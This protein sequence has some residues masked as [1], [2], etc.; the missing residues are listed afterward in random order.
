[1]EAGAASIRVE[2]GT[3]RVELG[4]EIVVPAGDALSLRL[5]LTGTA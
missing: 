2:G 4:R 5:R 1:V 3:L